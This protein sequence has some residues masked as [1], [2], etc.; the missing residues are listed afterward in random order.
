MTRLSKLLSTR[1]VVS[2]GVVLLLLCLGAGLA[3][4]T[5]RSR[6]QLERS[7]T[8]SPRVRWPRSCPPITSRW[9]QCRFPRGQAR[10]L[11]SPRGTSEYH[12]RV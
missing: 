5:G 11:L 1:D 10:I 7:R 2:F 4:E 8:G 3:M 12:A 9:S 6:S